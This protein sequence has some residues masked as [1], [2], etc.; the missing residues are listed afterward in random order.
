MAQIPNDTI[1]HGPTAAVATLHG[2]R[3]RP[4][5]V[6]YQFHWLVHTVAPSLPILAHG[7]TPGAPCT[8][9]A[10]GD[11]S[12][13]IQ[14]RVAP[15]LYHG[16]FNARIRSASRK[17]EETMRH[18]EHRAPLAISSQV[19]MNGALTPSNARSATRGAWLR[20]Q[21][22]FAIATRARAGRHE[23]APRSPILRVANLGR[24]CNELMRTLQLGPSP[25]P[26]SSLG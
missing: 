18:H 9:L 3:S 14:A 6:H 22:P 23:H 17:V 21:R 19:V 10:R 24:A 16:C 13:A 5:R 26:S 15:G 8:K 11:P 12:C 4:K 20:H 1:A 25:A 2:Q 7:P